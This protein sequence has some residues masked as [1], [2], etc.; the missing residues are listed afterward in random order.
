M[1]LKYRNAV[2]RIKILLL[3]PLTTIRESEDEGE[4]FHPQSRVQARRTSFI[5]QVYI[6]TLP[7]E[8]AR[9]TP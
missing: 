4:F 3:K 9:Q 5:C 7:R 2:A 1:R 6:L 8:F